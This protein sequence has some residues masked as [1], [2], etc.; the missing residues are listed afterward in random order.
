MARLSEVIRMTEREELTALRRMKELEMRAGGS[1]F[2]G[3]PVDEPQG[4]SRFGGIPVES[5][6]SQY[7][8]D[9]LFDKLRRADTAGDTEAAHVIADEIRRIRGEPARQRGQD[10]Y[11]ASPPPPPGFILDD[12]QQTP[13]LPPGFVLDQQSGPWDQD[14]IIAP[15]RTAGPADGSGRKYSEQE[16]IGALRKADAAGDTP[17]AKAIARRI[18]AM[19]SQPQQPHWPVMPK[20]WAAVASSPQYQ[21]LPPE[22]Q[23]AARRQYFDQVVAPQVG[24]PAQV[25]QARAQFDSQ[26]APAK[27]DFS[28][29]TAT[30]DRQPKP[31]RS[32]AQE[33]GRSLGLGVRAMAQG[34]GGLIGIASNPLTAGIGALTGTRTSGARETAGQLADM[35]GLPTPANGTERV[36]GN[37]T[38]AV[39]GGGGWLGAGRA[40]TAR[41]PG[42]INAVGQTLAAMPRTQLLS[43]TSGSAASGVTREAGG[44]PAQQGIAGLVGGLT[45]S[46]G[47][48]AIQGGVRTAIRG[49]NQGRQQMQRGLD[50]FRMMGVAPSVGQATGNRRTQ[51]LESLLAGAPT[52]G[53]VMVRAAERQADA[54]GAGLRA[55]ADSFFPN[56]SAERAGRAVEQG[57]NTFA[58]NVKATRKALYWQVDQLIPNNT[59]LALSRTRQTLAALTTPTPGAAATTGGMVN[60][61]IAQI[62]QNVA[63]D[64]AAAQ[65]RGMPYSAVKELRSRIGE[66]LSDFALSADRP[67]AQYKRLYAALSQD[68]EEAARAQGPA[69]VQAARRANGYMRASSE[70]LE[71]VQRV[72]DRNGG[73]EKVFSAVMAGTKDGGTTLRAVMQS[74]PKEGQRA[75]TGAVIKRMGLASP[76][77]Q[78]V[79]GETF[80]AQTFM[81]NWNKVSPEARRALFD[82]HGPR[83]VADMEKVARVAERIKS[84]SQVFANPSGTANRGLAYTYAASL[85][86]AVLTGQVGAATILAGGG[87]GANVLARGFTSP[88]VVSWL[89]RATEMPVSVLP[90]QIVILKAAA[91]SA[92]DE[93]AAEFAAALEGKGARQ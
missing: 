62:A 34:A 51:G 22:Q 31:Q 76:G 92:G 71:Q 39:T 5:P 59:A 66:E 77:Q 41:A 56:A 2:G 17:A 86:G 40:M 8:E 89:A 53:G 50:D 23:E 18:Q 83:F 90:Q 4:G 25:E 36:A 42:V 63:D 15:A 70:R 26:F 27:A 6:S 49:G 33:A 37:I 75:V 16:L 54:I 78:G 52:S 38:E 46:F 14:E 20:P 9:Q 13:P 68:L 19:R 58:S 79:T 91:K 3:I 11:G 74:L 35:L 1:R 43:A 84:G 57:I 80:S 21:S 55:R 93:E 48:A 7:S 10:R 61:R 82:R 81:T 67:T 65:G 47:V 28:G 72:V 45:P 85:A 88:V 60:P 24:D 44:T 73:P 29:V 69:A 30:V 87:A 12:E 64:M 32:M